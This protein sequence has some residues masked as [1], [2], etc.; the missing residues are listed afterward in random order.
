MQIY[1][2]Q[3]FIKP[4]AMLWIFSEILIDHVQG[5]FKHCVQNCWNLRSKEVL[6]GVNISDYRNQ[7]SLTAS[8]FVTAAITLRTSASR[9]GGTLRL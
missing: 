7:I 1:R 4:S 6:F 8:R 9:A 2:S 5:R 3:E